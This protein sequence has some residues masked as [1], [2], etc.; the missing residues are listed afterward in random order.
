LTLPEIWALAALIFLAAV[1][2]ASVGHGGA[3]GYL[4]AMALFGLAPEVMK[5]TALTLNVLVSLVAAS[6]FSRAG[7]FSWRYFWPFAL[8]SVPLAFL[9]GALAIPASYFKWLL[10]VILLFS[11]YR[12]LAGPGTK[13]RESTDRP[14]PLAPAVAS[15]AGIGFVSGLVGVGGGIFLSPLLL[16]TGWAG[17]RRTAAVSAVFILVNSVAGLAGHLSSVRLLPPAL[18]LWAGAALLGGT[19]GSGLGSRRLPPTALR[20]VLGAVLAVAGAKLIL[21]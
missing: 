7:Y 2:Y 10:G 17:I 21:T 3:S 1:L 19:I 5:P 16:F 14:L 8:G 6:R 9:G 12:L 13:P 11:A 4:A 18:P 15:G 20:R